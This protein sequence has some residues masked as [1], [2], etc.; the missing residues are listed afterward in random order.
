MHRYKS[1]FTNMKC[2][3]EPNTLSEYFEHNAIIKIPV[4]N[5]CKLVVGMKA[6]RFVLYIDILISISAEL[7]R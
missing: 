1:L 7:Y 4:L 6:F 5:I 3:C 2:I